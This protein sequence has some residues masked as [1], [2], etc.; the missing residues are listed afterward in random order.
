MNIK[1]L[2]PFKFSQRFVSNSR[3]FFSGRLENSRLK[4][5]FLDPTVRGIRAGK[6]RLFLAQ[7]DLR[8]RREA[9]ALLN[10]GDFKNR[11]RALEKTFELPP[12]PTTKGVWAVAIA[13][14]PLVV[15]GRDG[16]E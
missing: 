12:L 14:T 16:Q 4:P 10:T 5:R 2:A 6:H 15:G 1:F 11:Y 7:R 3:S 9:R 8:T 13:H